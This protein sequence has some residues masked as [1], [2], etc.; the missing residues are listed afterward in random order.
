[1]WGG[2]KTRF[3]MIE[4][5]LR[6]S[7]VFVCVAESRGR[8]TSRLNRPKRH[9]SAILRHPRPARSTCAGLERKAKSWKSPTHPDDPTPEPLTRTQSS[10]TTFSN[11]RCHAAAPPSR[12]M[13]EAGSPGGKK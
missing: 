5:R 7:F 9:P 12:A 4:F 6:S 8:R 11:T 3:E 13:H 10:C 1:M 2:G